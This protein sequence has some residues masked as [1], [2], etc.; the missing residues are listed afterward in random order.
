LSVRFLL[1]LARNFFR[2]AVNWSRD[3]NSHGN[4]TGNLQ[5][6]A[7]L[8]ASNMASRGACWGNLHQAFAVS[9]LD[10]CSLLLGLYIHGLLLSGSLPLLSSTGGHVTICRGSICVVPVLLRL[11]ILGLHVSQRNFNLP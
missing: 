9:A 6:G 8:G 11:T 4:G 5:C 1:I 3:S 10:L 2:R 7:T